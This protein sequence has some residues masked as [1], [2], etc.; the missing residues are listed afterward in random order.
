MCNSDKAKLETLNRGSK[1]CG[2]R[3]SPPQVQKHTITNTDKEVA[4]LNPGSMKTLQQ[5]LTAHACV[6]K[7][8]RGASE[9]ATHD[10][11]YFSL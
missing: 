1:T 2:N 8:S 6:A 3:T 5:D 7:N 10:T 4:H 9:T 11:Q